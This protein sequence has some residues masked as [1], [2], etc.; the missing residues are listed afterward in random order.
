MS[1]IADIRTLWQLAFAPIEGETHEA[2]LESFYGAQAAGYDSFRR[3]LLRG[4]EELVGRLQFPAGGVWIDVGGGTG[5]NLQFAGKALQAL[6]HV[7]IVDL[8]RPLLAVAGKRIREKGWKNVSTL[9]ADATTFF[10]PERADVI[11]FSYSLTMMPDWF[12][13]IDRARAALKPGGMIGIV[14]FYLSRKHAGQGRVQHGWLTR[15]LLPLWFGAD[16]VFLSADH[17]PY[18]LQRFEP[19]FVAERRGRIPYL[20]LATAPYY[21]F[22]GRPRTSEVTQKALC[23]AAQGCSTVVGQPWEMQS[24]MR[25]P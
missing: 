21:I 8:C 7:Y 18:L 13:A 1:L 16:N 20:P 25:E 17:L 15:S 14:D 4:R 6:S 5:A 23:G 3:R 12:A 9:Q 19:V 22:C 24:W 10:P 11:T 2:R